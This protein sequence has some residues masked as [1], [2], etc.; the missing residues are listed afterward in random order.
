M[1]ARSVVRRDRGTDRRRRSLRSPFPGW[2]PRPRKRHLARTNV[3]VVPAHIRV[4]G[5][6]LS[7][8]ERNEFRKQLGWKLGK[9]GRAVERVTLRVT[10]VNG[11]RG[12][13]DQVCRIKVVLNKLPSVLVEA[14]NDSVDLAFR[15]ALSRT[16]RAV[17]RSL[18]R[19]R[20]KPRKFGARSRASVD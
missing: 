10:D 4:L 15:N 9:L 18:Q 5:T 11:P 8:N 16:E 19:R 7:K 14:Q 2:V 12:G 3:P 6:Y 20:M 1:T 13:M 17:R